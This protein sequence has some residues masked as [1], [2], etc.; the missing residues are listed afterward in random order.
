MSSGP[1]KP[2]KI[3]ADLLLQIKGLCES[4]SQAAKL[5]LA[6]HVRVGAD[7][8]VNK[9][10][11]RIAEDADL[12]VVSPFP[13]VSRGA[14]KLLGGLKAFPWDVTDKTALDIGASTGGFTDV[15]LQRGI[16]KVYAVDV[17][18]GQLHARIR[19]DT[20]VVSLE[21]TNARHL[22]KELI[23][24]KIDLLV[25]DVSFISLTKVLPP[26]A[27]LLGDDARIYILIKPQFE[28]SRQDVGKGGVVRDPVVRQAC[29]DK[30]IDFA[31]AALHWTLIGTTPS[32]IK[33][34][35]GNQET[36]VVF[37]NGQRSRAASTG[38]IAVE[39]P[40]KLTPFIKSE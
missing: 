23:P 18:Y 35:K 37:A 27:P 15:L 21:R 36:I 22:T 24:E 30:I 40:S 4:R 9:T 7:H 13:Y 12:H 1:S 25:G 6:G 32:P 31:E 10:S 28:A 3:R 33:G 20:R 11:E 26:C 5:I 39:G 2:K 34:P 16:R 17:G 8:V 14:E 19:Q 29:V 38:T